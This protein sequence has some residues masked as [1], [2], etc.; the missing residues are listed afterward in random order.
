MEHF[1]F[2]ISKLVWLSGQARAKGEKKFH[3]SLLMNNYEEYSATLAMGFATLTKAI[4]LFYF[5]KKSKS[6]SHDL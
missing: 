4:I 3:V 2:F 5:F 1:V 6:N